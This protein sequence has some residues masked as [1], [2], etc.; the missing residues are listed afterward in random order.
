[1]EI[2]NH[3][4]L[5]GKW[6]HENEIPKFERVYN[7]DPN[8]PL[9]TQVCKLCGIKFN[10][11][12][13]R[14][15][16]SDDC[17]QKANAYQRKSPFLG[18]VEGKRYCRFC[19]E[20]KEITEF[21]GK[22]NGQGRMSYGRCNPCL[23]QYEF[24]RRRKAGRGIFQPA[25]PPPPL[26]S[27]IYIRTCPITNA[28]FVARQHNA[29]FHP[30]LTDE[31]I[32]NWRLVKAIKVKPTHVCKDC[33]V[34]F[35]AHKTKHGLCVKCANRAARNKAKAI[36]R[37]RKNHVGHEIVIPFKVFDRC[38]WVCTYCGKHTPKNMRGKHEHNS[39]ELD[40]IV[41]LSKGGKHT[42]LNTTLA[43]RSCNHKKS[44]KDKEVLISINNEG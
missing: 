11:S 20:V 31:E 10:D 2:E 40:H 43:C 41:P 18:V 42:Y 5:N 21:K 25:P 29:V 44:D 4:W 36:R 7:V 12:R 23:D 32:Y 6:V 34:E 27:H 15:Y 39:P 26:K 38:N 16:C 35:K 1:M 24:E 14:K 22:L 37:S 19:K 28:L 30:S 8:R 9:I 13:K 33:G 3:R 17:C